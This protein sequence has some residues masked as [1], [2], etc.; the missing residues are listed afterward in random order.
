MPEQR[1]REERDICAQPALGGRNLAV[2]V[3]NATDILESF[4]HLLL[5]ILCCL[6]LWLVPLYRWSSSCILMEVV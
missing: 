5:H 1:K 6:S 3:G 2:A 4:V